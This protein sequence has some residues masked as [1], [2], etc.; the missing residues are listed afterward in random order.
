MPIET[1][2][3]WNTSSIKINI[4]KGYELVTDLSDWNSYKIQKKKKVIK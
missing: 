3:T 1:I 4:P 2:K